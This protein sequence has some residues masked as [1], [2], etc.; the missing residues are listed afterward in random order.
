MSPL[1]N[2][3][4]KMYAYQ[5][6]YKLS[7]GKR[8]KTWKCHATKSVNGHPLATRTN[9][10]AEHFSSKVYQTGKLGRFSTKFKKILQFKIIVKRKVNDQNRIRN[11]NKPSYT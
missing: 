6:M 1:G 2:V 10:L 4:H 11:A 3:V 5:C 8:D 7:V 9:R